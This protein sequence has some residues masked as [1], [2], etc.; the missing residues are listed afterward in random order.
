MAFDQL[1]FVPALPPAPV[2]DQDNPPTRMSE[3]IRMAVADVEALLDNGFTYDWYNS[4]FIVP[5]DK[6]LIRLNIR[7]CA[8]C[9][10]GAVVARITGYAESVSGFSGLGHSGAWPHILSALSEL[11]QPDST[12][13]LDGAFRQWRQG[14]SAAPKF[15]VTITEASKNPTAFKRDMLALADRLEAEGS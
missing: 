14:F 15:S 6:H 10:A 4:W 3:A 8:T 13:Q 12:C 9:T 11:T 7:A 5:S 1:D 2:Y